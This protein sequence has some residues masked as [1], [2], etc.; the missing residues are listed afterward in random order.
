MTSQSTPCQVLQAQHL[1]QCQALTHQRHLCHRQMGTAAPAAAALAPLPKGCSHRAVSWSVQETESSQSTVAHFRLATQPQSEYGRELQHTAPGRRISLAA[2]L[3]ACFYGVAT[4]APEKL[5]RSC[6]GSQWQRLA[7]ACKQLHRSPMPLAPAAGGAVQHQELIQPACL[8]TVLTLCSSMAVC[9]PRAPCP[10]P[11]SLGRG[12]KA[13]SL[14]RHCIAAFR[15]SC[16]GR[17]LGC[18]TG[19]GTYSDAKQRSCPASGWCQFW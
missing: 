14:T 16:A 10:C 19:N 13:L 4:A 3:P 2:A 5:R 18:S 11:A 8:P 9:N 7:E 1:T 6:R 12:S 17:M 15:A